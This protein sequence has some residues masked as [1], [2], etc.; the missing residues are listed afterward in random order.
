MTNHANQKGDEDDGQHH[1]KSDIG[2]EEKLR[3]SHAAW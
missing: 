2:V 1:P 3:F